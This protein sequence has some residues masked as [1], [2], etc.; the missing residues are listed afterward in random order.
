MNQPM[1]WLKRSVKR[2]M[3]RCHWQPRSLAFQ[4][5]VGLMLMAFLGTL[6]TGGVLTY[7]STR[8]Q[9]ETL[10]QLQAARSRAV[11]EQIS[12]YLEDFQ[13]KLG[14][15]SRVTGLSELPLP[16][17]QSLLEALVRH[18][19]AYEM[20]AILDRSGKPQAAVTTVP[21]VD[22]A[23]QGRSVAFS[24]AYRWA[25]DYVGWVESE[26]VNNR[27]V[28]WMILSVPIRDRSE[29]IAGVLLAR[30]NL[31]F[32]DSVLSTAWNGEAGYTY[33]V[34]RRNRVLT[35]SD[36]DPTTFV[37]INLD[38]QPL[39]DYLDGAIAGEVM[40]YQGLKQSQVMGTVTEIPSSNSSGWRVVAELP[41]AE[42]YA[43]L[44]DLLV[45]MM[46][47]SIAAGLAAGWL[48]WRLAHR[49]LHPLQL[50]T[51]EVA[52]FDRTSLKFN[53]PN[54][55][56]LAATHDRNELGILARAFKDMANRLRDSFVALGKANEDLE[57]RVMDR[58]IELQQALDDLR[59]TQLQLIK[60]EKMSSLG[61][62][63][64]GLAHE[65]N[66]PVSFIFG[67]LEHARSYF[68]DLAELHQ[69]CA[70]ELGYQPDQSPEEAIANLPERV[71][72]KW[73]EVDYDF[74]ANDFPNLL[75][76]MEN[77]A[78][79]IR[80]L[81]RNLRDFA[82]L[83][84]AEVKTVNLNSGLE[85]TL[86]VLQNRLG[87]SPHRSCITVHRN[88]G[89]LPPIACYAGQINQVFLQ[90]LSNAIDILDLIDSAIEPCLWITS[91][92]HNEQISI[93]IRDN[94]SGIPPE[95]LPNI[96]DPFFTT[97]PVG[98]GTGLGL[99][100]SYQII[101]ET[102]GGALEVSNH[103]QGGAEFIIRLSIGCLAHLV[104]GK[105][106]HAVKVSAP[107]DVETPQP[108]NL[109]T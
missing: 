43:P 47:G 78:V 106:P 1:I 21:N 73:Q 89:D 45:Q 56:K 86:T 62:L 98:Q 13:R 26:R 99:S 103:P 105:M 16:V 41:L 97:K 10:N 68:H 9:I 3:H 91:H 4:I 6:A 87:P 40:Q 35:L 59:Q 32:M 12:T 25:E 66:N 72:Q 8:V 104:R 29:Q 79:R 101:V 94:G 100:I 53:Q 77:G 15:L 92:Y 109:K 69:L 18:D 95:I 60:T 44:R 50:L 11:A 22:L 80:D 55:D 74:I 84:E 48:S 37:P 54:I 90:I 20:V 42:A 17:Q 83:D 34:D 85:N 19:S 93:S 52:K 88:L 70:Q 36:A 46:L 27:R 76:S 63:V 57:Q 75:H 14:Y 51:S 39:A 58:T 24:R 23:S 38:Q 7:S 82:R 64:A 2:V 61:Q 28:R 102:H 31:D 108:L 107:M 5:R 49:A 30:V 65:I 96:F 67:N 81:I 33:L 71:R